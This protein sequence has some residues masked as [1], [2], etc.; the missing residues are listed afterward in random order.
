MEITMA[1]V[2]QKRIYKL[3][4]NERQILYSPGLASHLGSIEAAIMLG[5]FLYLQGLGA[6]PKWFYKT[7][8]EFEAQSFLSKAKQFSAM[9]LLIDMGYIEVKYKQIPRRRHFR[10]NVE[11]L[12]TSI[13]NE[14]E[15]R[16]LVIVNS[17]GSK[18]YVNPTITKSYQRDTSNRNN[19]RNYKEEKK[20]LTKKLSLP[21]SNSP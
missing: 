7:I 3:F 6:N 19:F 13:L 1:Q 14:T 4:D 21:N 8:S 9:N 20:K 17:D 18:D 5:Q 2:D 15:S 16:R 10:V 12:E 11:K